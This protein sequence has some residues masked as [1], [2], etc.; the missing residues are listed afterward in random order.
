Y[1]FLEVSR[2]TVQAVFARLPEVQAILI[3]FSLSAA[4]NALVHCAQRTARA[5]VICCAHQRNTARWGASSL[6][7][8][9][10]VAEGSQPNRPLPCHAQAS[11]IARGGAMK[12]FCCSLAAMAMIAAPAGAAELPLE[13]AHAPAAAY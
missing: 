12:K 8:F 1:A 13:A 10:S 3:F 2:Y 6:R 11:S 4:A 9:F 5:A 7:I